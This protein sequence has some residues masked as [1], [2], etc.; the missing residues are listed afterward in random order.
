MRVDQ[1]P[2]FE[3]PVI[4]PG[5]A[6]QN[7]LLYSG[8]SWSF[9]LRSNTLD[10]NPHIPRTLSFCVDL[11]ILRHG[12]AEVYHSGFNDAERKLTGKGKEEIA[13][14]AQWMASRGYKFDLIA[15]SPLKRAHE[16]AGIIAAS[17][18]NKSGITVWESLAPGGNLD[19]ICGDI[20]K[21]ED[22]A[23]V[24]IVGH[25]PSCSMLISR[26]ICGSDSA[27]IVMT[28]GG[29]AKI[30]NYSFQPRPSGELQW[31]LTTRQMM[32]MQ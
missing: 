20:N 25:E 28:K 21:C 16:T 30:R 11:Y 18:G 15:T 12:K 14:V 4:I 23:T 19:D 7:G 5:V 26:I 31:L 10:K 13:L 22:N 3:N 17:R 2:L 6:M 9:S 29:L 32:S 8:A 27:A 24:L 1:H